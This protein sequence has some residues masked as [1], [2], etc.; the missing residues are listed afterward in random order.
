[1]LLPHPVTVY[2]SQPD[3]DPDGNPIRRPAPAGVD[4][5]GYVQPAATPGG[6]RDDRAARVRAVAYLD[7]DAPYLDRG[8]RL[9]HDHTT[10]ETA[11]P[12]RRHTDPDGTCVFW[13][14]ELVA[15]ED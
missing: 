9:V 8:S 11:G 1:M 5:D 4:V 2:P 3:T 6:T 15:A 14:V 7:P 13:R 10:H 12:A